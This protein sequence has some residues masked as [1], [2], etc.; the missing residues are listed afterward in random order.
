MWLCVKVF[1]HTHKHIYFKCSH[2]H[3]HHSAI[4]I[5]IS[6]FILFFLQTTNC[7]AILYFSPI[8]FYFLCKYKDKSFSHSL[9][10]RTNKIEGLS[11]TRFFNSLTFAIGASSL[12]LT[13][14]PS[15]ILDSL[16]NFRIGCKVRQG[17]P[18]S[19]FD[20]NVVVCKSL[21]THTHTGTHLHINVHINICILMQ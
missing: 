10:H 5:I 20:H 19:L 21:K 17:K 6:Y 15:H 12:S 11:I 18:S 16:F 13:R 8:W 4:K 3:L 14:S 2:I 1:T 9:S 7:I